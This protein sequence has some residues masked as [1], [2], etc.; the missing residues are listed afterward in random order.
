MMD[1]INHKL[2]SKQHCGMKETRKTKVSRLFLR[3]RLIYVATV[4]LYRSMSRDKNVKKSHKHV[5]FIFTSID[6]T[7]KDSVLH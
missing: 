7:Y 5:D 2:Q 1:P 6:Y 4:L 3:L